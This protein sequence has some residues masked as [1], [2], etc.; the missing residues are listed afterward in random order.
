MV[1]EI[2]VAFGSSLSSSCSAAAAVVAMDS[3]DAD[4]AAGHLLTTTVAAVAA[5]AITVAAK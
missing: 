2:I 1:A 5:V 4:V 3:V